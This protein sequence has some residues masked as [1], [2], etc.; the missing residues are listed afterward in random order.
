MNQPICVSR[1]ARAFTMPEIL[2]VVLI[3]GILV[4]LA[5]PNYTASQDKA[6][7]ASVKENMHTVQLAC[8]A[9]KTDAG[10]Y[11]DAPAALDP[12]FPGGNYDVGGTPGTRPVNPFNS[13][14]NTIYTETMSTTQDITKM[15]DTPPGTGPG[16]MGQVG[17]AVCDGGNSYAVCGLDKAG[18]RVASPSSGTLV[19]SN[20]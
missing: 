19:L 8:E 6:K 5:L 3:I 16:S 7:L 4:A 10:K 11:P 15:R 20:Q 9:Y 1:S 13:S 14:N 18:M 17:Y 12:F 2:V